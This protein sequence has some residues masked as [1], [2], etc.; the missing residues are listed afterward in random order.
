MNAF[1][2]NSNSKYMK[3]NTKDS[4]DLYHSPPC[5]HGLVSIFPDFFLC[6]YTYINIHM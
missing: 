6:I 1:S 4:L 3:S 5:F 2:K